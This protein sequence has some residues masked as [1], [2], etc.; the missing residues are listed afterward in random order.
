MLTKRRMPGGLLAGLVVLLLL[1]Q[2]GCFRYSTSYTPTAPGVSVTVRKGKAVFL[3]G[4][5][6]YS[7]L[8]D[9]VAD[10]E[11]SAAKARNAERLR[12]HAA[13]ALVTSFFCGTA[14]MV[15]LGDAM[16]PEGWDYSGYVAGTAGVCFMVATLFQARY[17]G[18]SAVEFQDA[19][20]MY[21]DQER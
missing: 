5:N 16:D 1:A 19:L 15:F 20:N 12:G 13:A 10:H 8:A 3:K 2:S 11:P 21:N 18:M 17:L 7:S 4:G 6:E 9:A 14:V